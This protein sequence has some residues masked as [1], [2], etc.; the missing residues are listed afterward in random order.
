MAFHHPD[1]CEEP[2]TRGMA[3]RSL[4]DRTVDEVDEVLLG[5]GRAVGGDRVKEGRR[6]ARLVH[7]RGVI[8]IAGVLG[9]EDGRDEARDGG[10]AAEARRAE[11]TGLDGPRVEDA[12]VDLSDAGL[13]HLL[14]FLRQCRQ[15]R[16]QVPLNVR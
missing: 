5:P 10:L 6:E 14:A 15:E 9:L 7:G 13:E 12:L 1:S 16:V 3:L 11:D 8:L 4:R 2:L